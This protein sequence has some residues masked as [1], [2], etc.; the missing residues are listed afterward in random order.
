[1]EKKDTRKFSLHSRDAESLVEDAPNQEGR[2][3]EEEKRHESASNRSNQSV[4]LIKPFPG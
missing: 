3:I 2:Q 1:M 4:K